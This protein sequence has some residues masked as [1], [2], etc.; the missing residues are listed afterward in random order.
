MVSVTLSAF[1]VSVLSGHTPHAQVAG[2][3][4]DDMHNGRPRMLAPEEVAVQRCKMYRKSFPTTEIAL[5]A[6]ALRNRSIAKWVR[7][8]RVMV[9]VCGGEQLATAIAAGARLQ[10]L[11]LYAEA[12]SESELRAAV[13][14]GVGRVVAGSVQQIELLRSAVT[15]RAQD[16]VIRMT[17]VNTPV[18]A[19]AGGGDVQSGFRF[20]SNE[21]DTAIAAVLDHEWLNLVGLHCEVGSQDHDFV[22]YPAAI[23][24]MIAEM[25]QVRRNH[26]AVLTRLGLGGGRAIPSG[27]WAFELPQLAAQID[28]SLDDACGTLRF[29]RPLV[30]LSAGLEIIGRSAA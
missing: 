14:L 24:H 30:V 8:H 26:G 29:P 23:G 5:P 27:D 13:N 21:S 12:L 11:T 6:T 15:D 10:R 18:L 22:S 28:D 4:S 25:T 3:G 9:D 2:R 17:D 19:V 1:L 16:V 7:D 20:D